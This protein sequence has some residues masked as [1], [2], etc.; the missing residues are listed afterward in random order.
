M[1][2]RSLIHFANRDFD[3]K[4]FNPHF[5]TGR[6]KSVVRYTAKS[7][8]VEQEPHFPWWVTINS[9]FSAS[10]LFWKVYNE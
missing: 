8:R 5:L 9:D 3:L 7:Y 6:V 10:S 4:W 1:N 2:P